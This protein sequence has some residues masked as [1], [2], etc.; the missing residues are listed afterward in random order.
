LRAYWTSLLRVIRNKP[1]ESTWRPNALRPTLNLTC[2]IPAFKIR[3]FSQLSRCVELQTSLPARVIISDDTQNGDFLRAGE[4]AKVKQAF[5]GITVEIVPGPRK[6]HKE[7]IEFLL[8]RFS[9]RPTEYFHIMLDDDIIYPEFYS[10]HIRAHEHIR[11]SCSI[12]KRWV[13]SENGWPIAGHSLPDE[14]LLHNRRY[15]LID[16]SLLFRTAVSSMQNWLGELSCAV[17]RKEAVEDTGEF[18]TINGITFAGLNDIGSFLKCSLKQPLILI[19]DTLGC[20]RK[21]STGITQ[22]KGYAFSRS[23]LAWVA[24]GLIACDRGKVGPGELQAMVEQLERAWSSLYGVSSASRKIAYL[25]DI[26]MQGD[27]AR[28]KLEFLVFVE[29]YE[30]TVGTNKS[31][32]TRA[33]LAEFLTEPL[34]TS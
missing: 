3:Y 25:K 7:N 4:T 10:A 31:L 29:M 30:T 13:A 8:Q 5:E 17:F 14:F 2:L 33:K 21:S 12:S 28:F 15:L 9:Q 26:L 19:D 18:C 16:S 24:L 27:Y 32:Q 34:S 1:T 23:M 20:F 6:G 11:S 22:L